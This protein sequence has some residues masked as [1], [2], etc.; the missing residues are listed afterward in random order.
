MTD[1]LLCAKI[2][3]KIENNAHGSVTMFSNIS[4]YA[5]KR[6]RRIILERGLRED[7]IA[8]LIG[9]SGG[10]KFLVLAGLDRYIF[11]N[12]FKK[13]REPLDILGSSIG[14]WR[15]AAFACEDPAA[16]HELFV[17]AYLSQHYDKKP[18]AADVTA[19]SIRIMDMYIQVPDVDYILN[20]SKM[21]LHIIS[22]RCSGLSA[23]DNNALLTAS[24]APAVLLNLASRNALLG[25]FGRTMFYDTRS[26]SNFRSIAA[27]QSRVA[28]TAENI[29]GAILSS[30]SIPLVMEGIS[31]IPGAPEGTYRDGGLTDYH[32]VPVR[33]HGGILLYPHFTERIVP[34]WLDKGLPWRKPSRD[35]LAD[36]LLIAPSK[37]FIQSLPYGK[38]PDRTDFKKFEGN[39]SERLRYWNEVIKKSSVMGEEFMEAAAGN[40]IKEIMMD[41]ETLGN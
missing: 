11:S 36:I 23:S 41:A 18:S 27:P 10:P 12:W 3:A 9:A 6:A 4:V 20:R 28:L 13:R 7:D 35:S 14:A 1:S 40:R 17:N 15:G 33:E 25:I 26:S 29:R 37:K 30:G 5:G 24:F 19:E 32:P 34:G 22:A 39:D 21:R 16:K 2:D 31:S 8:G 38:I